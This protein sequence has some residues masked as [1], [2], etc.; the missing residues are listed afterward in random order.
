MDPPPVHKGS[1]MKAMLIEFIVT[2]YVVPFIAIVAS[3]SKG[4]PTV[5]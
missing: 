3:K 2:L 4:V 5:E 1:T